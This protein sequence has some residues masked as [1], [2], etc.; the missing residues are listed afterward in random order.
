MGGGTAWA[1]GAVSEVAGPNA[2]RGPGAAADYGS[3]VRGIICHNPSPEW[4]SSYVSLGKR[5]I[6]LTCAVSRDL[7]V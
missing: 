1:G 3:A 4:I 6:K 5:G 2:G 7:R